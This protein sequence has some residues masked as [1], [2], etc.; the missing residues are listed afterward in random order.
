MPDSR[1]KQR[2]ERESVIPVLD[3][4]QDFLASAEVKHLNT[5]TQAEYTYVL[6][7]FGEWCA[8]HSLSL[9]RQ[10]NTWSAIKAREK[11]DPIMLHRVDNQVV[12]CFLDYLQTTHKPAKATN[13]R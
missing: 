2:S 3:A 4:V 12:Y 7:V 1:I 8:E 5:K 11:H 10:T 6:T 13:E 9:N